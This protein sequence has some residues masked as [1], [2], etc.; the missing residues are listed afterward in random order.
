[1][2]NL[3]LDLPISQSWPRVKYG[4]PPKVN[5]GFDEAEN[6]PC[7]K[8]IELKNLAIDKIEGIIEH[9]K[10]EDWTKREVALKFRVKS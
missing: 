3:R 8:K 1:M 7:R 9:A 2:G 6:F 10:R 4:P 5:I